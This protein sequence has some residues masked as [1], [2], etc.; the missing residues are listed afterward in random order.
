[1]P[2]VCPKKK[3]DN[4]KCYE[5]G[6]PQKQVPSCHSN[7]GLPDSEAHVPNHYHRRGHLLASLQSNLLPPPFLLYFAYVL[8]EPLSSPLKPG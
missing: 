2:W 6:H 3:K 7:P 5:K 1:M 8:E 4:N